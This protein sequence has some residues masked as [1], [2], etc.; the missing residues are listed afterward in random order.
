[1]PSVKTKVCIHLASAA[2]TQLTVALFL[3]QYVLVIASTLK[4]KTE[5]NAVSLGES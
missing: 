3:F 4:Q 2:Y 5:D 1:M